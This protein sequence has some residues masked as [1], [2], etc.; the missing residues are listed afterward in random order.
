MSSSIVA[1]PA[2]LLRMVD[3]LETQC[4]PR[5]FNMKDFFYSDEA[6]ERFL[7]GED[8]VV[9]YCGCVIGSVPKVFSEYRAEI[10]DAFYHRKPI[11]SLLEKILGLKEQIVQEES[12][13]A[14]AWMFS[15]GWYYV[16]NTPVGAAK[17][18]RYYL[19]YGNV[20]LWFKDGRLNLVDKKDFLKW[21]LNRYIYSDP[22]L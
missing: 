10:L 21:L 17:R 22:A 5:E 2:N 11:I 3:W 14:W 18:I 13:R 8:P 19:K 4:S 16:D 20:P 15:G 7:K 9:G 6:V 12:H 1:N